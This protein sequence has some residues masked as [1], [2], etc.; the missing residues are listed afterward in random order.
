MS[1]SQLCVGDGISVVVRIFTFVVAGVVV[2]AVVVVVNVVV[3]VVV[4]VVVVI[5]NF[6]FVTFNAFLS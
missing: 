5:G 4:V 1:V 3:D 6:I 2:V